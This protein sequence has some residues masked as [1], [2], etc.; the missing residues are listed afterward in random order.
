M[1][2]SAFMV[3]AI[4]VQTQTS[5]PVYVID[6]DQFTSIRFGL[7]TRRKFSGFRAK[8]FTGGQASGNEQK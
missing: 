8:G 2:Q 6:K 1:M 5:A 7:F 3:V 4:D